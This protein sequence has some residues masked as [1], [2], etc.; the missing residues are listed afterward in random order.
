MKN[1]TQLFFATS[2]DAP[3]F[4]PEVPKQKQELPKVAIDPRETVKAAQRIKLQK[5]AL[6]PRLAKLAGDIDK[7]QQEIVAALGVDNDSK[8]DAGSTETVAAASDKKTTETVKSETPAESK[9]MSKGLEALTNR[10]KT[11]AAR[12]AEANGIDQN[13]TFPVQITEPDGTKYK[14]IA[15]VTMTAGRRVTVVRSTSITKLN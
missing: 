3:R 2:P 1:L 9:D 11:L 5:K 15:E 14:A 10:L 13:T 7:A 6:D 8:S 12:M 4:E